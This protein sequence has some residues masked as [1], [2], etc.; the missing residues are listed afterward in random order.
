MRDV[1]E[2]AAVVSEEAVPDQTIVSEPGAAQNE[3]IRVTVVV[4]VPGDEVEP[5]EL[6]RS[7]RCVRTVL[8]LAVAGVVVVVQRLA[9]VEA[10]GQDVEV[11]VAVEIVDQR[12]AAEVERVDSHLRCD[13]TE[14][15]DFAFGREALGSDAKVLRHRRGMVAER[16]R[17]QVQEPTRLEVVRPA[18]QELLVDDARLLCRLALVV[19]GS[20]LQRKDAA[21]AVVPDDAVLRLGLA[22]VRDREVAQ[23][24]RLLLLVPVQRLARL[25]QILDR[26]IDL[27]PLQDLAC[28]LD[29]GGSASPGRRRGVGEE[30]LQPLDLAIADV[31]IVALEKLFRD[32][33]ELGFV[34]DP[35]VRLGRVHSAVL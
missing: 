14:A 5:S 17:D 6:I 15:L 7:V 8:E 11:S 23:E 35:I 1:D 28:E 27:V 18:P 4:V 10:R 21:L 24:L 34:A 13:V 2:D 33:A 12:A 30:R 19:Q 29:L 9:L 3:H 26:A 16:H 25:L 31:R 22:Q 32:A 20:A